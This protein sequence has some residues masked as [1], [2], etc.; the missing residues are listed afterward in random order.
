MYAYPLQCFHFDWCVLVVF[1]VVMLL[2]LSYKSVQIIVVA[3]LLSAVTE[4]NQLVSLLATLGTLVCVIIRRC[5]C[6][7]SG[8][9]RCWFAIPAAHA[10]SWLL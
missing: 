6:L 3:Q 8:A 10:C 1:V 4:A 9:V 2:S 7:I 5:V